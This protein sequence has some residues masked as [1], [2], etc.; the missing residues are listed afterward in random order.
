MHVLIWECLDLLFSSY[1]TKIEQSIFHFMVSGCFSSSIIFWF[2]RKVLT[3]YEAVHIYRSFRWP[4][5]FQRLLATSS[6]ILCQPLPWLRIL[7]LSE[8]ADS[9]VISS[10]IKKLFWVWAIS[11]TCW[12]R[13]GRQCHR[14]YWQGTDRFVDELTLGQWS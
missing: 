6:P 1:F 10:T 3:L 4:D 12:P 9:S 7:E 13:A 11:L 8:T 14:G 2:D 5:L